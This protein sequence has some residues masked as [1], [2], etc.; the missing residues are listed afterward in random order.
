MQTYAFC[1]PMTPRERDGRGKPEED[2]APTP[3]RLTAKTPEGFVVTAPSGHQGS[4]E[5]T[6][7]PEELGLRLQE[8]AVG[9]E[10]LFHFHPGCPKGSWGGG[11]DRRRRSRATP[12]GSLPSG[13]SLRAEIILPEPLQ[14]QVFS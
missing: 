11:G 14:A 10:G 6:G 5:V 8:R 12:A 1:V 13:Q 2:P 3:Q 7:F 9:G 4:A